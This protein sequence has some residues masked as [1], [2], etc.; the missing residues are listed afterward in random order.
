M[1]RF[2]VIWSDVFCLDVFYF[3]YF[4]VGVNFVIILVSE[5]LQPVKFDLEGLTNQ[6]SKLRMVAILENFK[7]QSLLMFGLCFLLACLFNRLISSLFR[8]FKWKGLMRIRRIIV[9]LY[10]WRIVFSFLRKIFSYAKIELLWCERRKGM[11]NEFRWLQF[12][13]LGYWSGSWHFYYIST[14]ADYAWMHQRHLLR[15]LLYRV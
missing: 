13:K 8:R 5:H 3:I 4:H 14:L 12:K 11:K 6:R 9:I 2:H 10:N 15:A 1:K 7:F